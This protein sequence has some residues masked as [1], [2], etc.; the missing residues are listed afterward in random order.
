[1]RSLLAL[2][3]S[4]GFSVPLP[5]ARP[6]PT[7]GPQVCDWIEEH[8]LF[9]PGDLKGRPARLS[10]EKRAL[11]Y[12]AYEVHPKGS[13]HAG[14]RRFSRVA[15]SLRKG[16]AK[17]ELAAWISAAELDCTAPVR[18]VFE[19][20][21]SGVRPVWDRRGPV[22]GPVTDPYI[23]L[24]AYT[25]E[26]S[27]DLVYGALLAILSHEDCRI[28]H[29]FD[30]G[31]D[32]ILRLDSAGRPDGKAVPLAAAPSARD[33]ARTTFQSFDE[34]HRMTT[35][36]LKEAH[37]TMLANQTKRLLAD[38]WSLETTTTFAPGEGS[39]AEDTHA[40]AKAV[41]AGRRK[42]SVLFY[43]H[44]Q[45]GDDHDLKTKPGRRAA[46]LEASGGTAALANIL[47]A[48]AARS[49]IEKI[50]SAWDD[51]KADRAELERLYLNRPV[52]RTE[53]A[54]DVRA[55]AARYRPGYR[56][57]EGARVTLGFDGAR[58]W[59]STGLIA[60]EVETG[61]QEVVGKWERP[62]E[63]AKSGTPWE[64][65]EHEV[66][67]AVAAAFER[68]DVYRFYA[69]PPYW[70]STVATWAGEHG[71]KTVMVWSTAR[72]R[73]MADAVRAFVNAIAER[74]LSHD[75]DVAYARHVSNAHKRPL[76]IRDDKDKALWTIQKARPDSPDKIDL[77]MAGILSWE[78]RRDALTEGA[79]RSDES[80][81]E[82]QDLR[83]VTW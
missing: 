26:Q 2:D 30:L 29:H 71:E 16:L 62:P 47:G 76:R 60:T 45:A 17:T 27:E 1:M 69:D 72:A 83:E 25:E 35:R 3:L 22:G 46:L 68:W 7:L 51:P 80:M 4:H 43:F 5:D 53:K 9:G 81:Y 13:P 21:K 74:E 23:P 34:T 32:R 37:R 55:W 59:D 70:E 28:S 61:F 78:A 66:N 11:I 24:V 77:A 67:E 15:I 10:E 65:P 63:N 82:N 39:V 57:P 36:R 64:V 6:W 73:K 41:L 20:R 8:M 48:A 42:D 75:G 31:L 50:L 49:N 12:R 52:Q 44:R 33:G 19:E 54:F 79:A 14:R 58:R 38:A 56:I 40:Y 18:T